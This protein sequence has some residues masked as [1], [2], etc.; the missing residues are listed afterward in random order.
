M[1]SLFRRNASVERFEAFSILSASCRHLAQTCVTNG[2]CEMLQNLADNLERQA[3]D[4]DGA[5]IQALVDLSVSNRKPAFGCL[6][7]DRAA[8]Q[9][10]A[11][12]C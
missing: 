7:L 3:A 8:Q 2:A 11:Y 1:G 10:V 12:G 9:P 6:R 4:P 5:S